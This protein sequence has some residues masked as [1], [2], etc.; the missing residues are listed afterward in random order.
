MFKPVKLSLESLLGSA[1]T[2]AV[3]QGA[4]AL[5]GMPRAK[6][7]K[8]ARGTCEAWPR[9]FQKRMEEMAQ[10]TGELLTPGLAHTASGAGT[11]AFKRATKTEASPLCAMGCLRLGENGKLYLTAKSE[12]YHTPLGHAFPG[13]RL[14]DNA[15]ALGIPNATHNNTRGY[16]TR[17]LERELIRSVN[18]LPD[19]DDAALEAVLGSKAPHVLN[20]VINLETGSLAVEAG[21]KMMLARFH[22][23][24]ATDG[25][26]VHH[27]KTPVFLVIGDLE[28]GNAAN[29]HGTTVLTQMLRGLW[30]E[31]AARMQEHGLYRV[32]PVHINDIRD[33]EKKFNTY[34]QGEFRIAGFLHE[35]VLM[36]YGA[37]RL[38]NKYLQKAYEICH[39]HGVPV[40]AD[41]IQS[42]M[43]YKGYFLFKQYGLKPDFVITGKGFPGGEYPAS[44]VIT[45]YEMDTLSQFGALVT[46]GQE[47]LASL[48]YLITMAFARAN[49]DETAKNS[50][51]YFGRLK[52]L[53]KKYPQLIDKAEGEGYLSA[54]HFHSAAQASAFCEKLNKACIDVSA[55][56]Y[57]AVC[58]PAA[59]L[60]PP[61]IC[62]RPVLDL[63]LGRMDDALCELTKGG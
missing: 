20:R 29:Y 30:P 41:E 26:P 28:G 58:P 18:S 17:T 61:L 36:N 46:N 21:V 2:D 44:R 48:S 53:Q 56:T 3:C 52:T 14:L 22:D 31:M 12:H 24:E 57:K 35:I 45:T 55:Q 51:Y 50:R 8:L 25:R 37:I 16:I 33:F 19:G 9:R 47:E 27:G 63:L 5:L 34:N 11:T 43:W 1:Y 42:C 60:K 10:R 54:L 49:E 7:E 62:T 15:R 4:E 59:L 39:R 13:Y 32:C 40:L 23:P 6:A 38:D